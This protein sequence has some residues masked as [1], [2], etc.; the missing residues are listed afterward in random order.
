MLNLTTYIIEKLKINKGVHFNRET[1]EPAS[2]TRDFVIKILHNLGVHESDI[3]IINVIPASIYVKLK[4]N[5][6]SEGDVGAMCEK[7]VDEIKEK[8]KL[9]VFG[10]YEADIFQINID[11]GDNEA[12]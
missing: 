3:M 1:F 4:K 2:E 8:Y 11:F 12:D 5:Q 10:S 6:Y 9:K 7:V